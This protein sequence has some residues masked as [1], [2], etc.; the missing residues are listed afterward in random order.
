MNHASAEKE[1]GSPRALKIDNNGT[2]NSRNLNMV[3]NSNNI[4]QSNNNINFLKPIPLLINKKSEENINEDF[5]LS[6]IN[7]KNNNNI[8][9]DNM[10]ISSDI[11]LLDNNFQNSKSREDS[12]KNN[13]VKKI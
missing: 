5:G 8:D 12:I 3:F 11:N 1:R 9:P 6:E 13:N 2:K 7:Y 10:S 4:N